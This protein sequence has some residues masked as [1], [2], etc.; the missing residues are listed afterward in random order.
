MKQAKQNIFDRIAEAS[1]REGKI[2]HHNLNSL[3]QKQQQKVIKLQKSLLYSGLHPISFNQSST[4]ISRFQGF[5]WDSLYNFPILSTNN[6]NDTQT[7]IS[8]K[9]FTMLADEDLK[10]NIIAIHE[11]SPFNRSECVEIIEEPFG[12]ETMWNGREDSIDSLL[13]FKSSEEKYLKAAN[14]LLAREKI[15][16]SSNIS[17]MKKD[18][19]EPTPSSSI[20]F[21][22]SQS[23]IE[24][25]RESI[26]D[27]D[28][29]CEIG[30]K[31][32]WEHTLDN[33]LSSSEEAKISI[34]KE[35][36]T[37]TVELIP[38]H[39]D[40]LSHNMFSSIEALKCARKEGMIRPSLLYDPSVTS[41]D[42]GDMRKTIREFL[43]KNVASKNK[44]GIGYQP[45][46][47][48]KLLP[49]VLTQSTTIAF[50]EDFDSLDSSSLNTDTDLP[51]PSSPLYRKMVIC[52]G[53]TESAEIA[54]SIAFSGFISAAQLEF[55]DIESRSKGFINYKLFK[56][57]TLTALFSPYILTNLLNMPVSWISCGFEH[58]CLLTASGKIMSWG[59]GISGCLG[60]GDTNSYIYPAIISS[61][62]NKLF[63]Y[64]ECGGYHTAAISAEGELFTWGRGDVNQLGIP[65]K[66][67]SKDEFGYRALNPLRVEFFYRNHNKI[68]GIAC[69]EA[70]TLA[71]DSEGNI[72]AFGWAE[73]GQ[74]GLPS[75]ELKRNMKTKNIK[76]IK[77][78]A[79]QRI[80]KVGAGAIFSAALSDEGQLFTWGNG[81]QGQ[82]GLCNGAKFSDFPLPVEYLN[83]EF[84][85]DFICGES[86]IICLSQT[87]RLYGWGMGIAGLF[88]N[89]QNAYPVGSEIICYQPRI[90]SE[91][92]I[93][94]RFI[95]P[96]KYIED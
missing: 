72:Y 39:T 10:D 52:A 77:S 41:K 50:T 51:D 8:A 31:E 58:C 94:H 92:V 15:N 9:E 4:E 61:I 91:L 89:C 7:F 57:D 36:I 45:P 24:S 16:F 2:R 56:K 13:K 28:F 3:S 1:L 30:L 26:S 53:D 68:R 74:L 75:N 35:S 80:I 62:S 65:K 32:A 33:T 78:L 96:K 43:P 55:S 49:K 71:F 59:Y 47:A 6:T 38:E 54:G 67:L 81:E 84:I 5:L 42:E 44:L 29:R 46:L 69:G 86:H 34:I 64:L 21:D 73:D 70:H 88:K 82:L 90:L 66:A 83:K 95:T 11:K 48:S 87:G 60:H 23:N 93:A 20:L 19:N 63:I 37:S 27:Y 76:Q 18:W 40:D 17:A 25:N 85:I 22:I 79:E 14:T 12:F